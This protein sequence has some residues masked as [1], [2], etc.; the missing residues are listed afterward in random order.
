[1]NEKQ[2]CLLCNEE[3][4]VS[5]EMGRDVYT[6][7]CPVCGDYW[8]SEEAKKL[9]DGSR[10]DIPWQ[11]LVNSAALCVKMKE[12]NNNIRNKIVPIFLENQKAV[13]EFEK[14]IKR[15]PQNYVHKFKPLTISNLFTLP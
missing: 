8:M 10:N 12:Q 11:Q 4:S 13:A 3:A 9:I 1:M 15:T 7:S 14:L 5:R 2:H 6:V